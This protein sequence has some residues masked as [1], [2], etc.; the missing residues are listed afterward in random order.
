MSALAVVTGAASGM[1]RACVDRLLADGWA[2]AAVDLQAPSIADTTG[3]ACDVSDPVAVGELAAAVGDLG[4]FGALVHAAGISPTMAAPRR[5]F[6]V[7]LV[8]TQL[9]LDAFEP[10]AGPGTAAV[11][12]AS[13]AATQVVLLGADPELDAFVEDP[14]APGFLDEVEQRFEDPGLAYGWAKRGVV[15][16]AAR[17]AVTWGARGGRVVSLSPGIIDTGM[18]RQELDA[19]PMMQVMIDATPSKR[20]GRPDE[21]AAVVAFLVSDQASF[22]TGADLLVDGACTEGLR[23]MAAD[24]VS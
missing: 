6:E 16:S 7:D 8:G 13:S 22:L 9:L 1:G 5:I 17:A 24:F 4:T 3:F 11:C 23:G 20:L 2:I 21:I 10:L 15:R 14:M 12:F 18:G 19:Q